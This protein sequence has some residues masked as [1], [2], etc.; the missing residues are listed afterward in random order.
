MGA[1]DHP[2]LRCVRRHESDRGGHP[3]Y[4]GGARA[5][6]PTSTASG[7]YQWLDSSWRSVWPKYAGR[8][9][10]TAHAADASPYDQHLITG[11]V[12]IKRGHSNWAGAGCGYG[13]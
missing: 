11:I 12:V 2:F 3:L 10:P 8:S 7:H 6:N 9:A 1:I 13:T 5:E 4:L